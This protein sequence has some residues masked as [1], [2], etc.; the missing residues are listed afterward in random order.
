MRTATA[1]IYTTIIILYLSSGISVTWTFLYVQLNDYNIV[2][3]IIT[4]AKIN[5]QQWR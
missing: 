3:Y 4:H 5:R 1:I 2:R